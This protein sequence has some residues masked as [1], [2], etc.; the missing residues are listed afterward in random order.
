MVEGDEE[1]E[2]G[3]LFRYRAEGSDTGTTVLTDAVEESVSV[4]VSVSPVLSSGKL[5][6]GG[7]LANRLL[8]KS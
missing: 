3:G 8:R 6:K 4:E 7:N 1:G 2:T 5:G